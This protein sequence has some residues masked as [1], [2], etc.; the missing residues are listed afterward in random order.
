MDVLFDKVTMRYFALAFVQV[1]FVIKLPTLFCR[2]AIAKSS[3]SFKI[4][5]FQYLLQSDAVLCVFNV[6]VLFIV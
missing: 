2:F 6:L 3:S 5:H 1:W 4:Q